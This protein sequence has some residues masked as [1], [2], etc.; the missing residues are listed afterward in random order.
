MLNFRDA[1]TVNSKVKTVIPYDLTL[2]AIN[3]A[4]GWYNVI[5]GDD[6]GWI[7][8]DYVNTRGNCG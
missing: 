3:K 2:Q 6:N 8:A 1:P 7:S 4:P 5:F